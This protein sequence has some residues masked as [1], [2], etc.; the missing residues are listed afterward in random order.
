M[1]LVV[2][3]VYLIVV[4]LLIKEFSAQGQKIELQQILI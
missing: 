1:T 4:L 3:Y 2:N